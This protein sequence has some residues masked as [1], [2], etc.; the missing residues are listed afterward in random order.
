MQTNG[1]LRHKNHRGEERGNKL[2]AK[3]NQFK[4]SE[5]SRVLLTTLQKPAQ[6]LNLDIA[7]HV[8]ILE[9]WWNPQKYSKR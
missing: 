3:L 9:F 2:T 5:K 8:I 7:S 1:V 4:Y 6:E